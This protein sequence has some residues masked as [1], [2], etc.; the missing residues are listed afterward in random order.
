MFACLKPESK[1]LYTELQVSW[2]DGS[3]SERSRSKSVHFVHLFRNYERYCKKKKKNVSWF[4]RINHFH[5][6]KWIQVILSFFYIFI[7][8]WLSIRLINSWVEN[9]Y[10]VS[11]LVSLWNAS[12]YFPTIHWVVTHILDGWLIW[13]TGL[14]FTFFLVEHRYNL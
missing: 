6:C 3:A 11:P 7:G 13:Y 4:N 9:F 10:R 1:R 8:K 12:H 5:K 14:V 2:P